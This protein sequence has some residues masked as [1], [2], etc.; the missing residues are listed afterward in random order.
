MHRPPLLALAVTPYAKGSR[1]EAKYL[2]CNYVYSHSPVGE[3]P[4]V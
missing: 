4:T 2:S 1:A 3:G